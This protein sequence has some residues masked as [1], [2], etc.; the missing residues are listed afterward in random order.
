MAG[1]TCTAKDGT[2]IV[3]LFQGC[4]SGFSPVMVEQQSPIPRFGCSKNLAGGHRHRRKAAGSFFKSGRPKEFPARSCL[5][6]FG[7]SR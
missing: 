5:F 6:G 4:A 7:Q 3:N 1:E 2:E